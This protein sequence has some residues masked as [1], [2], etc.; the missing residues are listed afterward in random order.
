MSEA[1][2]KMPEWM[3]PYR[4]SFYSTG[5]NTVE[6]LMNAPDENPNLSKSNIVLFTL[7]MMAE[8]QVGLLMRLYDKGQLG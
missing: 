2:W 8:G 6:E 1:N 5:G 3:E 7:A 4:E